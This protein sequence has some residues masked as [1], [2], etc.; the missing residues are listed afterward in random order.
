MRV[1]KVLVAL[2]AVI[3]ATAAVITVVKMADTGGSEEPAPIVRTGTGNLS[4]VV[5]GIQGIE[6]S[7]LERLVADGR[8]PNFGRLISNGASGRFDNFTKKAIP[9]ATSFG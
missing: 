3:L 9:S 1:D 5:V 2:V 7:V 8:L 4:L 6:S